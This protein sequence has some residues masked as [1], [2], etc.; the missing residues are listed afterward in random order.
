MYL[1]LFHY[2]LSSHF[3]Y[4]E[5]VYSAVYVVCRRN[6][7]IIIIS[8]AIS[9]CILKS[10]KNNSCDDYY[11]NQV[12]TLAHI[13]HSNPVELGGRGKFSVKWM[14]LTLGSRI[15]QPASKNCRTASI[16]LDIKIVSHSDPK[17]IIPFGKS[18]VSEHQNISNKL[19]SKNCT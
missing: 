19:Q 15:I 16:F 3:Q 18:T 2:V 5:V 7:E 8:I 17:S 9:T 1:R 14:T 6:K 4:I 10:R 12:S 11:S 13:S